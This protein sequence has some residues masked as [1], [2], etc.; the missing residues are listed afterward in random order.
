MRDLTKQEKVFMLQYAKYQLSINRAHQYEFLPYR[1]AYLF[2]E[3]TK[4]DVEPSDEVYRDSGMDHNFGNRSK[5]L[6]N[7][8]N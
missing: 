5:C 2:K 8:Y 4:D 7:I 1:S 6:N 3:N